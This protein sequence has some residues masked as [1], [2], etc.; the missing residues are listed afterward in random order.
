LGNASLVGEAGVLPISHQ[1]NLNVWTKDAFTV[2]AESA[3]LVFSLYHAYR[4]G[5]RLLL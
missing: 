5:R 3:D 4:F 2:A 1:E